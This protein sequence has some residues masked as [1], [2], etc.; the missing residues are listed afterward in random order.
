VS[1]ASSPCDDD[2]VGIS[3]L[4]PPRDGKRS[5]PT[6]AARFPLEQVT[7]AMELTDSGTAVGKVVLVPAAR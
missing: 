3:A 4:G 5:P 2:K 7:E 6:V 1:R